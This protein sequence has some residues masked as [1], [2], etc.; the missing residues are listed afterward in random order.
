MTEGATESTCNFKHPNIHV[1]LLSHDNR[2][3]LSFFVEI[4][5]SLFTYSQ[6]FPRQL[7][8]PISWRKL[9]LEVSWYCHERTLDGVVVH[10]ICVRRLCSACLD[11]V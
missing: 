3:M 10:V 7:S 8:G 11:L 5:R 2:L 6:H 9:D 1:A 4:L